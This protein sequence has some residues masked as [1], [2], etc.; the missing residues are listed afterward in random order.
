MSNENTIGHMVPESNSIRLSLAVYLR[1]RFS[2]GE[3]VGNAEV[4][5]PELKKRSILN[6]S[7]YHLFFNL[8]AGDYHL[9]VKSDNYFDRAVGPVSI[10]QQGLDEPVVIDLLP[11]PHYSFPPGETLVRGMLR[12]P[13]QNPISNACLSW[14]GKEVEGLTTN[15]GEFVIFFLSLT[16]ED[17]IL[18]PAS[19]KKY[20][21]GDQE[22]TLKINVEHN[23][24]AKI[25]NLVDVEVGLTTSVN[26]ILS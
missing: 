21:R 14:K 23:N 16:E 12:D 11:Q 20:V 17:I 19:G 13:N 6:P 15:K 26:L 1:D 5:I 3:P 18:D 25:L 8:P 22:R 10:G 24:E 7:A 4:Q 9:Q 2:R